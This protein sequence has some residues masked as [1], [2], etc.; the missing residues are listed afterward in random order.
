MK[1]PAERS[2][3]IRKVAPG[4]SPAVF[5]SNGTEAVMTKQETDDIIGVDVCK[6]TLD[7]HEWAA[8][9]A[10][11]IPNTPAAIAQWLTRWT[12]PRRLALEPTNTY[13]LALAMAAHAAG[14]QVYLLDPYRLAH[15]RQGVGERVKAD[16]QDAELLERYLAREGSTLRVWTPLGAGQQRVWQLLKRRATLVRARV[17]LQQSLA[18]LDELQAELDTLL[19]QYA[20]LIQQLDRALLAAATALGWATQVRHCQSIPG[21]GALTALAMVATYHR[22]EFRR[23]DAFIAFMGLDVRVRDSGQSRGRRKLTKRGEPELR[24]LLFNA[25]MQGRRQPAWESY[26]LALRQRGLSSTAAF[27]ALGRKLARLCFALLRAGT[28]FN[29]ERHPGACLAT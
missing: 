3:D 13:H 25:A 20:R 14:H 27:V 10:Y 26:Y 12:V 17:Q 4:E 8:G 2:A 9:R 16:P 1:S 7:I 21:V 6:A 28:D 5:M 19:A 11:S 23:A 22:G 29:P 15:Y 24:R 18:D